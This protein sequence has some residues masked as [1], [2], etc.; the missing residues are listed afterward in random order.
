LE[1]DLRVDVAVIGGGI[2]GIT[3][4]YLLKKA[5]ISVA[6]LERGQF[7]A[8]DS[9]HTTAHLTYVTDQRLT[10]LVKIFG[11]DHAQAAWDAGAAAIAQIHEIVEAEKVD[12]EFAWVPG[13]LHA[14]L[15]DTAGETGDSLKE[16]ARL[17]AELGFDAQF[18]EAVPTMKRPG[19]RFA[20]QAKFHPRKYLRH[21]LAA[22]PG[23][24]SY[25]F[26]ESAVEELQDDPLQVKANGHTIQCGHVIIATHVPLQGLAGTLSAALFQT[27]L[28]PYSTY[29]IGARI[30]RGLIPEASFWD[31][32]DPYNY[33]RIDR[34]Q[35]FDYAIMGGADHK[36]GQ[37]A[38]PHENF[39]AVEKH[40]RRLVPDAQVDHRWS[41][42]VV[43]TNDGLPFIGASVTSIF[44]VVT[45]R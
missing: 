19:I 41:G 44:L 6:L 32:A 16:D 31:T 33:L 27:K 10:E 8:V 25:A 24:G 40:L 30:R 38:D 36:T 45:G 42:Q 43:E 20:N 3:A 12:A 15:D 39:A 21:L 22:I 9:G 26:E 1:E 28:A 18:E 14:P 34:R 35:E 29:A 23:G 17:A 5:G 4:A 11:R 7:G 37:S 2:T 13:Y